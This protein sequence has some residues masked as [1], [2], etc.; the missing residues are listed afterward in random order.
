MLQ[1]IGVQY[2]ITLTTYKYMATWT[3]WKKN[4]QKLMGALGDQ[5]TDT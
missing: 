3:T 4:Y 1:E 5:A 2:N